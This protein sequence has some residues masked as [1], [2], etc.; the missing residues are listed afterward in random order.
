MLPLNAK[1]EAISNGK[2]ELRVSQRNC[3]VVVGECA[4][5]GYGN[6][7][8]FIASGRPLLLLN[9]VVTTRR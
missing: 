1:H 2:A 8:Q 4:A 9:N 5:I 3:G 7:S 6:N